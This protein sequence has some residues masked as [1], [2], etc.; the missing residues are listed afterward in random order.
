MLI[1]LR[2]KDYEINSTIAR[3]STSNLLAV[4]GVLTNDK[5]KLAV[6]GVSTND[7]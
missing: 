7:T 3:V 2:I 1:Q 5:T 4:G 6:V